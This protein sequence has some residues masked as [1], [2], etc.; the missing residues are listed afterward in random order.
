VKA[1]TVKNVYYPV[2]DMRLS[3]QFYQDVL[4][5]PL[6]FVDGERWAQFKLNGINFALAGSSETPDVRHT[7]AFITFEVD[8][9]EEVTYVLHEKGII[10][11]PIRH[12][13]GHGRTCW[14]RDPADNVVQ[15]FQF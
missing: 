8:S 11:S 1:T 14:F 15:L 4:G 7:Q 5:L 6:Q 2:N 13:N 10:F 12:M 3:V 9:L